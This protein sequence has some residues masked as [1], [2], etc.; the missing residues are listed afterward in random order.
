[1]RG[2]KGEKEEERTTDILD[3]DGCARSSEFIMFLHACSC[4]SRVGAASQSSRHAVQLQFDRGISN[5][6]AIINLITVR[7]ISTSIF[8]IPLSNWS[9]TASRNGKLV[10]YIP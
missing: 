3:N 8:W 5:V 2:W 6:S 9:C 4:I 1:M 7:F 10:N